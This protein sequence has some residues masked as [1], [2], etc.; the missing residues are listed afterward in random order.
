MFNFKGTTYGLFLAIMDLF[1]MYIIKNNVL[2]IFKSINWMILPTISFMLAPWVFRLGLNH[3]TM[4]LLNLS[5]D[6]W[7]DI[8]V[9]ILGLIY[10]RERLTIIK[11]TGLILAFI[12]ILLFSVEEVS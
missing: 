10:F 7:S 6:L 3:S 1:S 4:T 5:W 9:S 12:S 11:S 8:L 2:G